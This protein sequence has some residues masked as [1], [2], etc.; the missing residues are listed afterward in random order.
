MRK[1]ELKKKTPLKATT[2][3]KATTKK[4]PTQT[5][6]ALTK[7]AD[8]AF[9]RYVRLRDC[10]FTDN[11]WEGECITCG[12]TLTV[13]TAEGKW[14]AGA[15]LGHFIGRGTK[16]LRYDE[17][18]C[19]LQCAHCNAWADKEWMQEQYRKGIVDKYGAKTL[20]ELKERA[21][22][23]RTN[24]REELEEVIHDSKLE[25]EY[26]LANPDIYQV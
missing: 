17:Y 4:R 5:I 22:I 14:K 21:K 9:S 1:S 26:M 12:K 3:L 23:T 11:G 10:L 20:K 19:N 8:T 13:L 15:N 6:P 16:E 7:K 2:S 25:V 18:N 24:S